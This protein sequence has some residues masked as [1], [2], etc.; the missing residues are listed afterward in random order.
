MKIAG[1]GTRCVHVDAQRPDPALIRDAATLI[2]AGE[3]VAFA[4]ET[5]Y[6]LGADATS[7]EAVSRIFA[8][9]GRPS[10]NPLIAHVSDLE[11]ARRCT[12]VWSSLADKLARALWPGPL[13][14]V[15]SRGDVT[16]DAVSA[17]LKTVALRMPRTSV[18][19]ALIE[20][21]QIPI[22]A[23][24]ANRSEHVSP[25]SAQHVLDDLDGRLACVLD[26]GPAQVGIESTV[27]DVHD[28]EP[29]VLRLGP[30]SVEAIESVLGV[31]VSAPQARVRDDVPRHSPG[32]SVRHYAPDVPAVRFESS[33][34]VLREGD[35]VLAVG[36]DAVDVDVPVRWLRDPLEAAASLYEALRALERTGARRIVVRM[37]P[38]EPAWAAVRDRLCRATIPA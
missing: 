11:M 18:A 32:Q 34:P 8:A 22:A 38:R 9:K 4:T 15:V 19:R 30:V 13:T 17:G 35:V 20:A 33:W 10:T 21:A 36:A 27:V 26:S 24:S 28:T 23:P 25:T 31:K 12:G 5:V 29:R 37:P 2:R 7:D 6:G 14:I 3:L 16:C 1:S